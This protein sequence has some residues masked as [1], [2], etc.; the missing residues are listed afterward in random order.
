MDKETITYINY[1]A[2]F[3]LYIIS[4]YY[5]YDSYTEIIGLILLFITNTSFLLYI[6]TRLIPIIQTAN[7]FLNT[8]NFSII[9]GLV[10]FFVSLLFILISIL[11]LQQKSSNTKGTPI[12]LPQNEKNKLNNFK[13]YMIITFIIGISLLFLIYDNEN[14]FNNTLF[15][16]LLQTNNTIQIIALILSLSI[17]SISILQL[18]PTYYIMKLPKKYIL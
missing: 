15:S 2:F 4:F 14:I 16:S 18:F 9:F 3:I 10:C 7:L 13:Y 17:Y 8:L 11:H 1:F 6:T 5:T 12:I